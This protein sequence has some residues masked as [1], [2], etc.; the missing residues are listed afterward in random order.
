M[1]LIIGKQNIMRTYLQLFRWP[2]L[3]IMVITML[4][5]RYK[6]ILPAYEQLGLQWVSTDFSFVLLLLA[7]VLTAIGG[8]IVN[9]IA[10]KEVDAINKPE[11]QIVGKSVSV[12]KAWWIYRL[13]TLAG[14]GAAVL[15]AW[16]N[17]TMQIALL[18]FLVSGLLWF[19]SQRYQC[20]PLVGN[21]V[22]AAVSALVVAIVWL[23]DFFILQN[24]PH[25]FANYIGIMPGITALIMAYTLFAFFASLIR[26]IVKDIE[27][28]DG[29]ASQQ[30]N[31]LA[32]L[33]G[34]ETSRSV[35]IALAIILLLMIGFWQ[36]LLFKREMLQASL[37]LIPAAIFNLL[38]IV[39]LAMATRKSHFAQT[40]L[41]LKLTMLTG[42]LTMLF[43]S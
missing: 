13:S 3:L 19:Y 33:L 39:R 8:N 23:L 30:C 5:V 7:V 37:S 14:L 17:D 15:L 2:N 38:V 31:T 25:S 32:V 4:L 12:N 42:M 6:I 34:T 24:V 18:V 16:I 20:L 35:S 43:L 40:S 21:L 9:D 10:D 11:K 26:E 27:D 36:Y 22:V 41:L 1:K 29:D 28:R